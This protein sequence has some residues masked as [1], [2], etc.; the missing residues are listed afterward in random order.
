MAASLPIDEYLRV[1]KNAEGEQLSDILNAVRQYIKI[2][3]P[4]H[5]AETIMSKAGVALQAIE[6]ES[7]VN[8]LRARSYGLVQRIERIAAEGEKAA[9]EAIVE[10]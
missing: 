8:R 2:L 9:V 5:A 3:N 1:F 6:K 4:P 7:D 10:G